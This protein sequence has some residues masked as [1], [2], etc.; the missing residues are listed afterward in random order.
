MFESLKRDFETDSG[1]VFAGLSFRKLS[2]LRFAVYMD[3]YD[4]GVYLV[5]AKGPSDSHFFENRTFGV[6]FNKYWKNPLIYGEYKDTLP[7]CLSS[8]PHFPKPKTRS[9]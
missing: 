4:F 8:S 1:Y 9:N 6:N 3:L 5:Y 7:E 2:I